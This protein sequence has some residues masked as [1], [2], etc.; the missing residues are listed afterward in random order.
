MHKHKPLH[1]LQLLLVC[2]PLLSSGAPKQQNLPL[3]WT[4]R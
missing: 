4:P 2:P 1:L 3:A